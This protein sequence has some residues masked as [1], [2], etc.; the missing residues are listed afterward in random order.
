M[1]TASF[2]VFSLRHLAKA[3]LSNQLNKR[4][5]VKFTGTGWTSR[6]KKGESKILLM[7]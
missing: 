1:Q 3:V 4:I 7:T 6:R 5:I 2:G